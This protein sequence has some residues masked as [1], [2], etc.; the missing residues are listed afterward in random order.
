MAHLEVAAT[1]TRPDVAG[2][3]VGMFPA[4]RTGMGISLLFGEFGQRAQLA[5]IL[6]LACTAGA[7]D[8]ARFDNFPSDLAEGGRGDDAGI[9]AAVP[10]AN[11]RMQA[12]GKGGVGGAAPAGRSGSGAASSEAGTGS[13]SGTSGTSADKPTGSAAGGGGKVE[14]SIAGA[15]ASGGRAGAAAD[16]G[17]AGS[18]VMPQAGTGQGSAGTGSLP[19]AGAPDTMTEPPACTATQPVRIARMSEVGV[20][21]P[22]RITAGTEGKPLGRRGG[23]ILRVGE[24]VLWLFHL[25]D[26]LQ[27]LASWSNLD[28]VLGAPPTV[29]DAP[30]LTGLFPNRSSAL[31]Q[32]NDAVLTHGKP[33]VL[34]YFVKWDQTPKGVGLA[35]LGVDEYVATVIA[36]PGELFRES[37]SADFVPRNIQG[38]FEEDTRL[39]GYDC[40]TKPDVPEEQESGAHKQPC[41]A[42][43]V[44]RAEATDGSRYEFWDGSMWQSSYT[45][46][47]V[48]L[49]HVSNDLSVSYNAYLGKY[50]A[51]HPGDGGIWLQTADAPQGPFT[52]AST[53]KLAFSDELIYQAMEHS[54]L[55]ENCDR[56]LYV[57]YVPLRTGDNHILKLELE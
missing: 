22:S 50:L 12:G 11:N 2:A 36:E 44:Q 41:R 35:T 19:Q 28:A 30:M 29:E 42:L 38:V 45:R 10:P 39:Y 9:D 6:S 7:C 20:L 56:T 40:Q 17:K 53:G 3:R 24:R 37:S 15:A 26:T 34:F 8:P 14:T 48:A 27:G 46:A 33:E 54:S 5:W 47:L 57:T 21:A 49:D 31:W 4:L 52:M 55:R 32:A 25:S 18:P 16:G 13:G 43:R 51:V 23:T 1:R